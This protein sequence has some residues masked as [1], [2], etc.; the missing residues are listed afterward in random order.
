MLFVVGPTKWEIYP[1]KLP[2]WAP[3]ASQR[4]T[5]FDQIL[6][7]HPELPLVDVRPAL[8]AGRKTAATY[9]PLNSHWTD[10]GAALAWQQIAPQVERVLPS[11]GT[12]RAPTIASVTTVDEG[13][14]FNDMMGVRAPNPWTKPVLAAPLP[15]YQ[16]VLPDGRLVTEPGE[17]GTNLLDLPRT[18]KNPSAG[19]DLTAL[20]LR[21]SMGDSLSPYLQSAFGTV[22]QVRHNIDSSNLTPNVE[23][24]VDLLHPDFVIYEMAERHFNSGLVDTTSWLSANQY[25]L[26]DVASERKWEHAATADA[27]LSVE[28][29]AT[30]TGPISVGRLPASTGGCV[31]RIS[32]LA[33][34][35]GQLEVAGEGIAA[36]DLRVAPDSNVL[37][38]TLPSCPS[39]VRLQ[40]VPGSASMTLT[41]VQVRSQSS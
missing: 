18:T 20:V 14:E 41:S 32:L 37:F 10:F 28:G 19:N 6:A 36:Q 24:M 5:I 27:T 17:L 30:F 15:D 25:D 33:S 35:P 29:S 21:D 2:A 39:S 22:V 34:G 11:V 13:N 4:T 7:A 16:V 40:V 31:V 26:A 9:S 1:D 38:A 3:P 23:A 12:V 8:V